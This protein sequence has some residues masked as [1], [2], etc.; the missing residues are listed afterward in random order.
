VSIISGLESGVFQP[1]HEEIYS[2][3]VSDK[4]A[5]S[6]NGLFTWE[7]V[8][9]SADLPVTGDRVIIVPFMAQS[10]IRETLAW[11]TDV[12]PA[13]GRKQRRSLRSAPRQSIEYSIFISGPDRTRVERTIDNQITAFGV[14][15]WWELQ[16]VGVVTAG[17]TNIAIDTDN[18]DIRISGL[19]LLWDDDRTFE[20]VEVAAINV[21]SVDLSRPVLGNYANALIVPLRVG[22]M[23]TNSFIQDQDEDYFVRFLFD[24]KEYAEID[25]PSYPQH[26]GYDVLVD[27]SV[28]TESLEM[29][30]NQSRTFRDNGIGAFKPF[31]MESGSGRIEAQHWE[32][33]GRA[34][35]W[36][37]RQWLYRRKGR[38]LPFF[39]PTWTND[40]A[41]LANIGD[42]DPTIDV[43][44]AGLPDEFDIMINLISG[45]QLFLQITDVVDVDAST[46]RLT[47]SA[48]TGVAVQVSDVDSI[49]FLR[50]MTHGS[51][52]ASLNYSS[53]EN[54]KASLT[55]ETA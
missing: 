37:L 14:P 31:A 41:L 39:Y 25:L 19:L 21:G 3:S 7:F 29:Q 26:R 24:I 22:Y 11:K 1:L 47:L 50:L 43:A 30:V 49:G 16:E 32:K 12:L 10:N 8:G 34:E 33:L 4:G 15:V 45:Q 44:A 38:F 18:T 36:A 55:L 35:R 2:L 46:Q 17:A 48:P 51:D 9:L 53:F 5:S 52:T 20:S 23:K 54:T 6:I 28:V 40:L 13:Y 42:Q 27:P